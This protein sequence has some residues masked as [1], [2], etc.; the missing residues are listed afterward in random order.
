MWP[1]CQGKGQSL[2]WRVKIKRVVLLSETLHKKAFTLCLYLQKYL[3]LKSNTIISSKM[4]KAFTCQKN[5]AV[6]PFL[7]WL[8]IIPIMLAVWLA[9]WNVHLVSKYLLVW[10]IT[11]N[12]LRNAN[13]LLDQ[14]DVVIYYT[15]HKSYRRFCNIF[16]LTFSYWSA[17]SLKI[18]WWAL[19][20]LQSKNRE[21]HV[22][23]N[24]RTLVH[25][26]FAKVQGVN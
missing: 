22:A 26:H 5:T 20:N 3:I 23:F 15:T 6:L 16:Q 19:Q 2:Y 25:L 24:E 13:F 21:M 9:G 11:S 14:S 4:L 12:E 18:S 1:I 10:V 8:S 17:V 7:N